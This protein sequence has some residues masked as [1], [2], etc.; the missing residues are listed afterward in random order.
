MPW[1]QLSVTVDAQH[2]EA[3]E[4]LLLTRGALAITLEDNADQ[5]LL[6]PAP[7][8]LPLWSNVRLHS[9]FEAGAVLGPLADELC[10]ANLLNDPTALEIK[11]VA[12]QAWERAWMD[13][14]Q[15]MQFGRRLWIYPRHVPA[16]PDP[17]PVIIRL[18]PGLAFGSGT[19]PTT[20]LCLNWIDSAGLNGAEVIDYGCGSGV[21]AIAA[22][23]CGARRVWCVDHDQQALQATRENADINGVSDRVMI[24][25]PDDLPAQGADVVLANILAGVLCRLSDTLTSLLKPQACVVMSGMLLEQAAAVRAAYT[26]AGMTWSEKRRED[27]ALLVGCRRT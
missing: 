4:E 22:A 23:L 9:L 11:T 15:P 1:L 10:S 13:R 8:E 5:A 20:A 3:V 25:T 7:G 24:C 6:E 16:P 21:L 17:A 18:D 12:D 2:C 14:Y 27:W 19:H 26:A